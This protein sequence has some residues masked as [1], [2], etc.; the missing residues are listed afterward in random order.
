MVSMY[1]CEKEPGFFDVNK[2]EYH[3]V[4]FVMNEGSPVTMRVADGKQLKKEE[5]PKIDEDRYYWCNMLR[6]ETR[7]SP[8]IPVYEDT[9]FELK[10]KDEDDT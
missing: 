7:Y 1:E 4:I 5:L 9:V 6:D 8:Y 2:N 10:E 3:E